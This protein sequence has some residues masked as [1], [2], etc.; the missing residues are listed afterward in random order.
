MKKV[1][2]DRTKKF[3]KANLHCH[4]TNSDGRLTPEQIKEKYM[5]EGYSIVAYTDHEHLI[6]NSHLSDDN[7]LAITA[8]EIAIKQYPNQSTL[9]NLSMKVCHLNLYAKDEKNVDTPCYN[10]VY[11]HFINDDIRNKIVHSCGEY[12]RQYGPEGISEIIRIANSKGFLVS[13]NHPRWS[14]ENAAD[15]LGYEGLWAVEIY[16]HGCTSKGMYNYAINA[17]DDFL[18]IGKKMACTACDDNHNSKDDCF[19]GFVMINADFLDYKSIIQAM[20]NHNMY[21]SMGPYIHELYIENM[22]AYITVSDAE[23]VAMSTMGRRVQ[24]QSINGKECTLKF[25]IKESDGY[26][27]FDVVDRLGK[28]ANTCAYFIDDII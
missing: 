23:F 6:D 17:Y 5:A 15:Y 1:L 21:S 25:D 3:Y 7:F 8:C 10:S 16:N 2:L 24:V 14:L 26:I 11:D 13:Y 18:R 22:V 4:S 28:R 27:R 20:E 9:K 12:D 19:G